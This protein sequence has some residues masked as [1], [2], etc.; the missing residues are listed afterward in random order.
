MGTSVVKIPSQNID[1]DYIAFSF[2]GKHSY[3]DMGIYRV[4]DGDR[5]NI[6]LSPTLAE[7]VTDIPGGDGQY[8]FGTTYK[9]KNF[10]IS[11]AFDHMTE[12]QFLALKQ[13]L[14]GKEMGDLWFAEEPYKVYTAKVTGSATIK[15]ICFEE[16]NDGTTQRIYKGEGSVSFTAYYP[17][18][19]TPDYVQ[20]VDGTQLN[21]NY[22]QSYQNFRNYEQFKR[23]LPN[24]PAMDNN[25]FGD[26]PFTFVA[27]LDDV[28]SKRNSKIKITANGIEYSAD[29]KENITK[30]E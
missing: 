14:N 23:F 20:L 11:F 29:D 15:T 18:A 26:L 4:S 6:K 13:W 3:E 22:Y 7:K 30:E 1:Y 2:K 28:D 8:Y 10:D 9:A 19:H 24:Y 12:K 21:G 25:Q 16:M 27:Y 5:Y 17:F